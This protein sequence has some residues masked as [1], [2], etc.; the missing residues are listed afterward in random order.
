MAQISP[1]RGLRPIYPGV[2]KL[3]SRLLWEQETG[4]SSRPTRT[5]YRR[6]ATGRRGK[7]KPCF[8]AE[9]K[10]RKEVRAYAGNRA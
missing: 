1:G 2:A 8:S 3:V 9:K 6:G 5:I 10:I 4:R 7:L